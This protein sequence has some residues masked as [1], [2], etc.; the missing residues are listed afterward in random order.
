MSDNAN[1]L[2]CA[3]AAL[4]QATR[5]ARRMRSEVLQGRSL[6]STDHAEAESAA[7]RAIDYLRAVKS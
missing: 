2:E 3:I 7:R 1:R 6:S 4:E 5:V